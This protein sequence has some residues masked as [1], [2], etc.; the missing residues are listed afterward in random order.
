MKRYYVTPHAQNGPLSKH[1]G[2]REGDRDVFWPESDALAYADERVKEERERVAHSL[3]SWLV[4]IIRKRHVANGEPL[5][6]VLADIQA[7]SKVAN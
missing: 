4:A 7:M 3:A 2:F 5:S 6:I 1:D